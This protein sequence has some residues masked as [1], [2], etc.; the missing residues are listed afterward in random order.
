M[1]P[2]PCELFETNQPQ[3]RQKSG[4]ISSFRG[5]QK[6]DDLEGKSQL[7]KSIELDFGVSHL[8][9]VKRGESID[10]EE[11]QKEKEE[12]E[13]EKEEKEKEKELLSSSNETYS[14]EIT[15]KNHLVLIL[16]L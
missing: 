14:K 12:K 7:Q 6:S 1:A 13:K 15:E 11:E 4:T 2:G 3:T 8:R 16:L 5:N 9:D 10:L